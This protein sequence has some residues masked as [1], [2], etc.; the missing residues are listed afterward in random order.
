[1]GICVWKQRSKTNKNT[2]LRSWVFRGK[3]KRPKRLPCYILEALQRT[4]WI[5]NRLSIPVTTVRGII[6]PP[7][8]HVESGI[9]VRY[10]IYD[11]PFH[12]QYPKC[13]YPVP[14]LQKDKGSEEAKINIIPRSE[15]AQELSLT[16]PTAALILYGFQ[17]HPWQGNSQT[18]RMGQR[19]RI[20]RMVRQASGRGR[21]GKHGRRRRRRRRCRSMLCGIGV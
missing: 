15:V 5:D 21:S 17:T 18:V 19:R 6:C 10:P 13:K 8:K 9:L 20:C 3:Q 7:P 1:M 11:Q 12:F 14:K 16:K 2:G 4:E